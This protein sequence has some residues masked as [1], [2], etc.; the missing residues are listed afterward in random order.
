MAISDE[1]REVIEYLH[2]RTRYSKTKLEEMPDI[3]AKE[4]A[5][6]FQ[7]HGGLL[8]VVMPHEPKIKYDYFNVEPKHIE[9]VKLGDRAVG[10]MYYLAGSAQVT[11]GPTITNYAARVTEVFVKEDGRWKGRL[12]HWSPLFGQKGLT[13]SFTPD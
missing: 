11:N 13:S 6:E 12:G 7:S 5:L 10:A 3:Y 9:T 2:E 1:E 4:G 8:E